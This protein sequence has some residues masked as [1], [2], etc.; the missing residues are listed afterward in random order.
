MNALAVAID[1]ARAEI[2]C[3]LPRQPCT[4]SSIAVADIKHRQHHPGI[5]PQD[6]PSS[7]LQ[8]ELALYPFGPDNGFR[9]PMWKIYYE[10]PTDPA[11]RYL[12]QRGVGC[13]W[14]TDAAITKAVWLTG[15]GDIR[16]IKIVNTSGLEGFNDVDEGIKV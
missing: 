1:Q 4:R 2:H 9:N 13:Y 12:L 7:H 5:N 10:H 3:S 14:T 11:L 15:W 8:M 16:I 6:L